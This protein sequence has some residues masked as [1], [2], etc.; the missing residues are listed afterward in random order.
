MFTILSAI[1]LKSPRPVRRERVR[2]RVIGCGLSLITAILL[3]GCTIH[4]QGE[5]QQ[6]QAALAAGK[7]FSRSIEHRPPLPDHPTADDLVHYALLTNADLEQRYWEWRS[8]I[9]QIPQD[10][11]Q[12]TN[13]SLSAGTTISHGALSFDRTTVT[14]GNDPMADIVWPNK[15]STAARR[16]L[17]TARAVGLRFQQAKYALRD[18]VLSAYDDYALTAELL[19]LEQANAELL[20]TAATVTEARN[21]T[22]AAGQQ[23][24]LK[25]RNEL[26]LSRND[27]AHL[28]SQ[29]PAQRAVLNALLNRDP[30]AVL[31]IP[32]ELPAS[33]PV[34]YSDEQ[35][36]V[37]AAKQ[38]P[39]LAALAR[40]IQ[41]RQASIT[42][43]QLQYLPDFSLSASTDLSGITQTLMGMVTVPLLRYQAINAAI[44]QAQANLR[45][46]EAMRRQTHNDLNARIVMDLAMIH[47]ADRQLDLLNQTILPRA[48]QII[49]ITRSSYESGRATLLDLLDAQRSLISIQRL[50]A[51]L[52]VTR[53]KRL[54]D[55]E[56]AVALNL[57]V[58][59][60]PTKAGRMSRWPRMSA[61]ATSTGRSSVW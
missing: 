59:V 60:F 35:L 52:H 49:I 5:N 24:L 16:A 15:I 6:R 48:R 55:V 42:L 2:V 29:L 36:L 20:Q 11:T 28:Q 8:A 47:D 37:M 23:D 53:A 27:I 34:P 18:K 19:R 31:P 46:S 7:P 57:T 51:N 32:T 61:T 50:A 13:L 45:A 41:S 1:T 9:E 14:V 3:A 30:A 58:L 12:P 26:D 21:R 54:A 38:N 25:A 39:E 4:P 10:G 33:G 40:D 22:G 17:E 43:A 56:A 44:A